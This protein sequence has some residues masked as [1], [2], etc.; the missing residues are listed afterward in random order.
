MRDGSV[1]NVSPP[2]KYVLAPGTASNAAEI[3]PPVAVSATATD[4]LRSLNSFAMELARAYSVGGGKVAMS[5]ASGL[6]E[7][8]RSRVTAYNL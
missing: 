6:S 4:S 5:V 1:Y 7:L 2:R 3:S 8:P